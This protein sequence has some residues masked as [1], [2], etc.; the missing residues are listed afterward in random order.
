MTGVSRLVVWQEV[1]SKFK[2]REGK[3]VQ[4]YGLGVKEI[5][6]VPEEKHK[7]G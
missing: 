6:E 5:W 4:T 7:P 2:L 3:D 1:M